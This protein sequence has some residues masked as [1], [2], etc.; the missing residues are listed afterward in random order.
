[1]WI[2]FKPCLDLGSFPGELPGVYLSRTGQI[3]AFSEA[4]NQEGH[5]KSINMTGQP[6]NSKVNLETGES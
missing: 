4:E 3:T 1:M 5:N 6:H 2:F